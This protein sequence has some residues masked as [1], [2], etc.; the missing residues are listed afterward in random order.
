MVYPSDLKDKEWQLI[1]HHFDSG[2]YGNRSKHKKRDLVNAVF[3]IVKS[4][5]QWR[6]LPANFPPYSTVHSFYRRC[7]LKGIWERI[8]QRPCYYESPKII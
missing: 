5:C 8:T 6:M 2:N 1:E 4:G 7:R 3:Y